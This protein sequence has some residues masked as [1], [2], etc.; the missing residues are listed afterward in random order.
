MN[1]NQELDQIIKAAKKAGEEILKYYQANYNVEQKADKSPV[2]GADL[3]S[4][5]VILSELEDFDAGILSEELADNSERLD[6]KRVLIVDPMDGTMDFIKKTG[7]FT[8]MIGLVEEGRPILGVVYKPVNDIIYYA[9][10]GEGAFIDKGERSP[11]K[12]TVSDVDDFSQVEM[13]G[14]RFHRSE[15]ESKLVKSLGIPQ[16]VGCGSAGL[17]IGLVAEGKA[18]L[19]INPSDKTLEWDV[20]AADIIL[21]EA[22]GKLT[23]IKGEEFIYNKK[24]PRNYFGYLASN[25]KIHEKVVGELEEILG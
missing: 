18:E 20:C 2:T 23:D 9:V 3:A 19:N 24:D 7:E 15:T 13:V 16:I 25:R 4:N 14:S 12:I 22:G 8:I 11:Q 10:K 5:R 21:K 1:I 6:K 17:K